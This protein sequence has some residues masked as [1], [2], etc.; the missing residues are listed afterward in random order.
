[1][2]THKLGPDQFIEFILTRERSETQS[3]DVNWGNYLNGDMTVAVVIAI[4]HFRVPLGLCFKPRVGAQPLIWKSFFIQMQI[5]LISHKKGCAPNL[6]LTVRVF[7]TR[8]WPITF[9]AIPLP[10]PSS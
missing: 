10:G 9:K 2:K 5:N 6:T 8:K 4:G 3:D 7:G 1:M